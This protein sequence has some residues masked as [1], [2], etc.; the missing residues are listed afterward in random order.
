MKT[1][2]VL[3]SFDE[4]PEEAEVPDI[5]IDVDPTYITTFFDLMILDNPYNIS[6]IAPKYRTI[7]RC[8]LAVQRDGLL[9]VHVPEAFRNEYICKL[10]IKQNPFA[11]KLVPESLK[12][13]DS[14]ITEL[15]KNYDVSESQIESDWLREV[16]EI[17]INKCSSRIIDTLTNKLFH[18]D[19]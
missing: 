2:F 8:A 19:R 18:I 14:I 10:A 3:S 16:F 9:L 4:N 12:Y 15:I 11:F 7:A 1:N 6:I 5:V 13:K 17:D